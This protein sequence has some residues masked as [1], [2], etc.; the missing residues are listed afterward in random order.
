MGRNTS[1]WRRVDF[2]KDQKRHPSGTSE[3]GQFAP[4]G[5]GSTTKTRD[6]TKSSDPKGKEPEASK[7]GI[8][9]AMDS[10][11]A[12]GATAKELAK[13]AG[14]KESEAAEAIAAEH[15]GARRMGW[16][17]P[18][19]RKMQDGSVQIDHGEYPK[20]AESL[21]DEA[22][23][24]TIKDAAEAM[25]ANP[26]GEKAGYYADEIHY[27][28]MELKAREG[29]T[30]EP[31]PDAAPD[32]NDSWWNPAI[33]EESKPGEAA[34]ETEAQA[35]YDA[36]LE[37]FKEASSAYM[38]AAKKYRAREIGDDE[39]LKARKASDAVQKRLDE[40]EAALLQEE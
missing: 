27:A 38:D 2:A 32:R 10:P 35:K 4:E 12:Y 5:G 17:K 3:G 24:Y 33:D 39:F 13:I 20:Y 18:S 36:V 34:A 37:E 8:H 15:G 29:T 14:V 7:S 30:T 1:N 26:E 31:E 19:A 22:L 23:R 11:E 40:A 16:G 9:K 25:N 28:A 6:D 21:S